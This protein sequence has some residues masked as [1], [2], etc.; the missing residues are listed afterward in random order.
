MIYYTHKHKKTK[1]RS[2]KANLELQRYQISVSITLLTHPTANRT[3]INKLEQRRLGYYWGAA[4]QRRLGDYWIRR[5]TRSIA[6]GGIILRKIWMKK[7]SRGTSQSMAHFKSSILKKEDKWG[8][9][10][11][12]TTKIESRGQRLATE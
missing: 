1:I 6:L 5:E 12:T 10:M 8:A 2:N 7:G 9:N 3:I 4:E 11:L